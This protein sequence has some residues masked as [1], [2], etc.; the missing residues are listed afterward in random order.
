M[1]HGG[2]NQLLTCSASGVLNTC[3]SIAQD[4]ALHVSAPARVCTDPGNNYTLPL[5]IK[6]MYR[7]AHA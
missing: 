5:H 7:A 1:T 3:N 6:G 4:W 2:T